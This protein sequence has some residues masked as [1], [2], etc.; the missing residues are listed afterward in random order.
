M[1]E[2]ACQIKDNAL[3][4]FSE[5]DQQ[6]LREY[7][8]S[9]VVRV[10]VKGVRKPRSYQQLRGYWAACQTVSENTEAPGW[11]TKEQVDFNCR[12][13]LR[14][15]DPDLIVAKPDGSIAFNY[16]SIAYKNLR[17]IEACDY[18]SKAF[19]IMSAKLGITPD[20]LL[21]NDHTSPTKT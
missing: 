16:R 9:Q 17:H 12:V 5:E 3:Y 1:I 2:I 13:T 6:R 8:E 4:P 21:S 10:T 18:F 14:F 11:Q 7:K 20:E 15:Y 19:E